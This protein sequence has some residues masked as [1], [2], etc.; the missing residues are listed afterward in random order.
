VRTQPKRT[1]MPSKTVADG[2]KRAGRRR[3]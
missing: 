2:V 3:R 1:F